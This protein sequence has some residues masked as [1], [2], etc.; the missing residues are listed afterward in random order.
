MPAALKLSEVTAAVGSGQH[1]RAISAGEPFPPRPRGGSRA[2]TPS[3]E[4]SAVR[5]EGD[6]ATVL[7]AARSPGGI[8]LKRN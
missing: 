4:G 1:P 6:G 3:G 2:A 5:S 7:A 8:G